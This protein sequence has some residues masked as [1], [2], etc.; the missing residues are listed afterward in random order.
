MCNHL[1]DQGMQINRVGQGYASLNNPMKMLEGMVV[2]QELH[3]DGNP[4][5]TMCA[6]NAVVVKDPAGNRKLSKEKATGR[7]DGMVAAVMGGGCALTKKE[8]EPE[9]TYQMMFV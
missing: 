2:G 5:M 4:V 9:K 3:H 7:I 6:A 1:A 8:T